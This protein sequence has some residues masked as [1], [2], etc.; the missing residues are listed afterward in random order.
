M[1]RDL[2]AEQSLGNLQAVIEEALDAGQRVPCIGRPEWTSEALDDR[3]EAVEACQW[4]PVLTACLAAAR[5]IKASSGVWGG[6]DLEPGARRA[7]RRPAA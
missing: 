3:V 2:D 1:R 6:V 4:C 5:T 7:V